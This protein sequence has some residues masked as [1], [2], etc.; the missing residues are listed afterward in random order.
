MLV[1]PY[2]SKTKKRKAHCYVT[3]KVANANTLL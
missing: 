1:G 3:V 2:V